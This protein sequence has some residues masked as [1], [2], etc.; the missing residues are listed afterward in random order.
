VVD[1]QD[2]LEGVITYENVVEA[3]EDIA[4]ETIASMAG[5]TEKISEDQPLIKRFF[6]R[7]PW[8]IVTLCA[9]LINVGV[10]SSFQSYEKG[11]LTFVLF[12]VPLITGLSGNIGIQ[13]STILV[14]SMAIGLLSPGTRRKA[15]FKEL[16]I[17]LL[18]GF[19]FGVLCGILVYSV[20]FLGMGDIS[21]SPLGVGLIVGVGLLGA[22]LA[23][24]L[25]GALSPLFFARMGVDPAIASGPII[26]AFNDFLSMSIYFLIAMGLSTLLFG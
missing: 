17:G 9:G 5:T 18:T 23:G 10:M 26:S 6:S 14:R 3:I 20:D 12:F 25:L 13:S 15:V 19:V 8:L 21:I 4:D 16:I 7:A 2:H 22:C 1:A 11:L 24:T